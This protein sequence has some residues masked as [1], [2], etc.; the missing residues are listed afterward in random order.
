MNKNIMILNDKN[1]GISKIELD[2]SDLRIIDKS[3]IYCFRV[4]VYYNWKD[5]NELKIGEKEQVDFN[6]YILSENNESALIW[7]TKGYVEKL[8]NDYLC[9]YFKFEN[10]SET[11]TYMNKKN[12][13]DILL[14]SLEVKAF[15]D[16]K[17]AKKN[18]IVYEF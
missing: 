3:G 18:S 14:N 12:G 8:T 13:F 4:C 11:I 2:R 7:P 9:F 17:D 15:I 6:E 5:I 1:I 16:Y 10:M